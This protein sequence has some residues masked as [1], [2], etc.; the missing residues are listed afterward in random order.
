MEHVSFVI[1][2][3]C[4]GDLTIQCIS[5]IKK[6]ISYS[7]YSIVVVDNGSSDKSGVVL[8]QKYDG[9]DNVF[10]L[11]LKDNIGFAKANNFGYQYAKN[12]LNARY[13]I[14]TNSDTIFKQND[15]IGIIQKLYSIKGFEI[16]GPD[17]ITPRG[18]HQNPHRQSPLTINQVRKMLFIKSVFLLYF[19]IK[20][21]FHIGDKI[22]FLEKWFDLK[23]KKTQENISYKIEHERVVLQGACLIF[24][25]S[26]IEKE[27]NAFYPGTFMY[28]EEDIL[29]YLA[30]K[31]DY[32]LLY[33]PELK[34]F[35]LDGGAT[36]RSYENNLE[37][38]IFT[39]TYIVEGCKLLLRIM[40]EDALTDK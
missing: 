40:K 11:L 2:N 7:N 27:E 30:C 21:R 35:H 13:I 9:D 5:S 38:N 3:Y 32:R 19:N 25:P 4:S 15:F 17:L 22:L 6:N 39:Y 18:T 20:K 10:V 24:S 31:K 26:F 14:V 16:A 12:K 1:L 36:K 8:Q 34:V 28:G 23:D 29:T 33:S 37:K